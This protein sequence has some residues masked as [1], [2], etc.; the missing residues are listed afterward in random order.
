MATTQAAPNVR[1]DIEQRVKEFEAA[2]NRGDAAG[3]AALYTQ[4]ALL[5]PPNQPRV[6]GRPAIQQ[7]WQQFVSLGRFEGQLTPERVEAHGAAAHE[8]GVYTLRIQPASG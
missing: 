1:Q 4:D 3:M 7:F 5:L 8:I 2:A 6:E